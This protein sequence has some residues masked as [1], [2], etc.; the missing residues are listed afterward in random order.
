M[1]REGQGMALLDPETVLWKCRV[2]EKSDCLCVGP[3]LS[4]SVLWF[5]EGVPL[6]F[7]N[8]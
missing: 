6:P 5:A 1:L 3:V 8:S 2:G 7:M 4:G